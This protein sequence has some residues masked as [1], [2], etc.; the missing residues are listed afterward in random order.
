MWQRLLYFCSVYNITFNNSANSGRMGFI[1]CLWSCGYNIGLSSLIRVKR[2][3]Q[4]SY[5]REIIT[6]TT[7][8][9]C[10]AVDRRLNVGSLYIGYWAISTK[11]NISNSPLGRSSEYCPV[12]YIYLCIQS[13]P[14]VLR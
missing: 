12:T 11:Y 14:C 9:V 8:L 5:K 3:T 7:S 2:G 6:Y 10:S 13:K 1:I 4:F